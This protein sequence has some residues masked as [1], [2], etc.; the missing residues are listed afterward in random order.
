MDNLIAR[1]DLLIR[2][3]SLAAASALGPVQALAQFAQSES[4]SCGFW[5]GVQI[6]DASRLRSAKDVWPD[7]AQVEFER[8][9]SASG[10]QA[11]SLH[12]PVPGSD[13]TREFQAWDASG[14]VRTR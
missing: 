2:A 9:G 5:D 3:T 13:A 7:L 1:R 4:V 10:I 6:V 14:N 8:V 11:A 12:F